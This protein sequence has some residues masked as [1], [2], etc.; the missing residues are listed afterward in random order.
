MVEMDMTIVGGQVRTRV[1]LDGVEILGDD[2]PNR[3]G[4]GAH[5]RAVLGL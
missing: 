1:R 2:G 3:R 4:R 5:L